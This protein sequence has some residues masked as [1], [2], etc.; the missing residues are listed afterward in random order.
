MKA[1]VKC[2]KIALGIGLIAISFIANGRDY[3]KYEDAIMNPHDV[4]F[5]NLSGDI[6]ADE[7]DY[8]SFEC[9]ESLV[10]SN[11]ELD[12]IPASLNGLEQLVNVDLSYNNKLGAQD[13]RPFFI[14]Q[15]HLETLNLKGC[16][17][18]SLPNEI[19]KLSQLEKLNLSYNV[20]TKIPKTI[21]KDTLLKELNFA[22][23]SLTTLPFSVKDLSALESLDVS[24]NEE[25]NLKTS[26]PVGYKL[27]YLDLTGIDSVPKSVFN[28]ELDQLKLNP[29]GFINSGNTKKGVVKNLEMK[30]CKYAAY[31]FACNSIDKSK[32]ENATFE[33]NE[34]KKVPVQVYKSNGKSFKIASKKI[35]T[36]DAGLN[37]MKELE[38]LTIAAPK[39]KKLYNSIAQLKKL[40]YLDIEKTDLSV[41]EI[42]R[43]HKAFPGL[44]INYNRDLGNAILLDNEVQKK[45]KIAPPVKEYVKE[46]KKKV[47][48][49]Q[50][51]DVMIGEQG[52]L[53]KIYPN[54]FVNADGTPVTEQVEVELVEFYD[55]VDVFFS[56]IPMAYD[57]AS[58]VY[59]F[60]SGGMFS[61]NAKTTSGKEVKLNPGKT[62]EVTMPK[63]ESEGLSFY[64]FDEAKG[65]WANE[66]KKVRKFEKENM[67]DVQE[68]QQRRRLNITNS[69]R[70]GKTS[71]NFQLVEPVM[72]GEKVYVKC[73]KDKDGD[74]KLNFSDASYN[75]L[76][77]KRKYFKTLQSGKINPL[78]H[79]NK[80]TKYNLVLE[81]GDQNEIVKFLKPKLK[82]GKKDSLRIEKRNWVYNTEEITDIELIPNVEGDNFIVK[83][84]D[85]TDTIEFKA[86]PEIV[87]RN[88]RSLQ[89]TQKRAYKKYKKARANGDSLRAKVLLDYGKSKEK[90]EGDLAAWKKRRGT[91]QNDSVN[92]EEKFIQATHLAQDLIVDNQLSRTV[93]VTQLGT[94]NCDE[95]RKELMSKGES[96]EV[97]MKDSTGQSLLTGNYALMTTWGNGYVNF[98]GNSIAFFPKYKNAIVVPLETGEL[99][100]YP[101][102][103]M[104]SLKGKKSAEI[105]VILV[106]P[107][108]TSKEE[109]KKLINL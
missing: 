71:G 106:D 49:V 44:E 16:D 90:Y 87:S 19:G 13:L 14:A 75:G 58:S 95:V 50:S 64:Y 42:K 45:R 78:D 21:E 43:I 6:K 30:D 68:M 67:I 3:Y 66:D 51:G 92:F 10:L 39:V 81:E 31:D 65:R 33:S 48:N 12:E 34:L 7:Y 55:P 60:Y 25:L 27:D 4:T 93:P 57:S 38:R 37:Q 105:E 5:L 15:S 103:K 80:Y 84:K 100:I 24:Y 101:S 94:Y 54:S 97:T 108:K 83:L 69:F 1:K 59:P 47:V 86:Y 85:V 107:S 76:F 22:G 20:L 88:S 62:I 41:A 2:M 70:M 91:M 46:G 89:R 104:N 9:L 73:F 40:T 72:K 77:R 32:L 52:T 36:V 29:K 23:N 8:S 35:S 56:G 17:L 82:R 18:L 63:R 28:G 79:L 61:L 109:V 102:E 99:A 96:L 26:L 98:Y 53:V 74:L 11:C